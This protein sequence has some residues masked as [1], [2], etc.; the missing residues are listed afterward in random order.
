MYYEVHLENVLSLHSSG[1]YY[2][3]IGKEN[4]R[5]VCSESLREV[6]GST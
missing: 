5:A 6:S 4:V 3:M 2:G 1:R